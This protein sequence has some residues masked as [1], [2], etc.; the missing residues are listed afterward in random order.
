MESAMGKRS[1]ARL[2]VVI[3]A[4][5]LL[6]LLLAAPAMA[7]PFTTSL[8]ASPSQSTVGAGD[9]LTISAT[10]TDTF[11]T[12]PV[13]GEVM[14]VEQATSD[15]GPWT[16]LDYADT[17][18]AAGTYSLDVYPAGTTSYYRFV[19]DGTASYAA[20]T[21][22]TISVDVTAVGPFATSLVATPALSTVN[23]GDS[24][25][26]SAVLTDTVNDAPV[27]GELVRVEAAAD[28]GGPWSL[29]NY[30]DNG[31]TTGEYILEI[32]P[33]QTAYYRFVYA[34]DPVGTYLPSTSNAISVVVTP[35]ATSLT[36]SPALTTLNH[37]D[38]LTISA[39]LTETDGAEPI[40]GAALRVESA[41]STGGPWTLIQMVT[42]DG[43]TGNY[44]LAVVP[45]HT[46][47]YRFVYEGTGT[48]AA[49]TSNVLTVNVTSVP[50]S[51][52]ASPAEKTV[53]AGTAPTISAVLT[54]TDGAVPIG[55]AA[56]R[57]EQATS[58][59]GPW[60]L[61]QTVSNDGT[62]GNYSL[63]VLPLRTTYYRFVYEGY[64]P[65][66][67]RSTAASSP[68]RSSPCSRPRPARRRSRSPRPSRS[69]A[70]SR[71][72]RPMGRPSRSRPTAST[73][74]S[75]PSTRAPTPP[76]APA[77]TTLPRSRSRVPAS[78][79]SRRPWRGVTSS[80]R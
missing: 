72:A 6:M 31:A 24:L 71:P 19:Y 42:N 27:G 3:A 20:V 14:R 50:T 68:S 36:A 12:L 74:A 21:S 55:G 33:A 13:S 5:V 17:G 51:L 44:S 35:L 76:R 78:T 49:V 47:Y 15:T 2:A 40:G 69:R 18:G 77:S 7:A 45:P 39:V 79:S 4:A 75:G 30:A 61:L 64:A 59:S 70:P 32:Y 57:V 16:L 23:I 73:T 63:A 48:Y 54:E 1:G 41:T 66:T 60:T 29:V 46:A 62:T 38:G 58:S 65:P 11:N 53:T 56:L 22:N 80:S 43:T 25:T 34:P 37:G 9:S 8:V 52:T 67:R 26:I 28:S 10:L